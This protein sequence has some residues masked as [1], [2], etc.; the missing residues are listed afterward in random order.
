M[1]VLTK[2]KLQIQGLHVQSLCHAEDDTH[3]NITGAIVP[4]NEHL[5]R[6]VRKWLLI[7]E[8]SSILMN[9]ELSDLTFNRSNITSSHPNLHGVHSFQLINIVMVIRVCSERAAI[10]HD[11]TQLSG[12]PLQT[13]ADFLHRT[14]RSSVTCSM[15][16]G[17]TPLHGNAPHALVQILDTIQAQVPSLPFSIQSHAYLALASIPSLITANAAVPHP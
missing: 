9:Q 12:F 8:N 10:A 6:K 15:I 2:S 1:P 3:F 17:R 11:F 16:G 13:V 7:D 4:N 5:R 14:R